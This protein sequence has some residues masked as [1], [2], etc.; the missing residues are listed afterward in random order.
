ME[1]KEETI[2]QRQIN[3]LNQEVN[4]LKSMV[5]A[6]CSTNFLTEHQDGD[7]E[8]RK[9]AVGQI[10]RHN[11]KVVDAYKAKMEHNELWIKQREIRDRMMFIEQDYPE[12]RDSTESWSA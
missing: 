5:N 6:L 12:L 1:A 4:R 10:N 11:R 7:E 2:E 8:V 9:W 3:K